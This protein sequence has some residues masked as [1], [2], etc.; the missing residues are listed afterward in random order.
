VKDLQD[1]P[2]E[3][4]NAIEVSPVQWF[5]EVLERALERKPEPLSESPVAP[6]P[7]PPEQRPTVMK[8]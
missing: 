7:A 5:D 1:I 6:L 8:H 3:V 4:K 2:E